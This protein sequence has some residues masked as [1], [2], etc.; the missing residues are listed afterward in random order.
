MLFQNISDLI[1]I[2]LFLVITLEE[3][4]YLEIHVQTEHV[5]PDELREP[6]ECRRIHFGYPFVISLALQVASYHIYDALG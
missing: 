5:Q 6:A 2:R 4:P 3:I 1:R